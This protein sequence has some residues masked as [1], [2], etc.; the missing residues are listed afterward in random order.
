MKYQIARYRQ[1]T[2]VRDYNAPDYE[3]I[4]LHDEAL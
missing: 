3:W 1:M 2:V 4:Q